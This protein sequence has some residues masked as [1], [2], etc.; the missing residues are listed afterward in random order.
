[1]TD[2]TRITFELT[3]AEQDALQ[4]AI[5]RRRAQ[6]QE[7]IRTAEASGMPAAV[8]NYREEDKVLARCAGIMART[9]GMQAIAE[10]NAMNARALQREDTPAW[11]VGMPVE[12]D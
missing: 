6:V 8:D 11:M 3:R 10:I 1:M 12:L 4:Y 2:N 7:Y 5:A 9:V